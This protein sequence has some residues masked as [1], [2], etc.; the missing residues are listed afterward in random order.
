MLIT[1]GV[2]LA[3]NSLWWYEAGF[4][5]YHISQVTGISDTELIKGARGLIS[6]FNSSEEFINVTVEKDGEPFTLFN[7]REVTHLKDV[8]DLFWLDYKVALGTLIYVLAYGGVSLFYQRR[9]YWHQ[10][11]WATAIGSGLTLA[12]M[13]ALWIGSLINFE[14]LFIQFHLISFRNDFWELNPATDYLVMMF[15]EGFWNDT[16]FYIAIV[17]AVTAVVLG[18][19]AVG[20]LLLNKKDEA[21]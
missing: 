17:A 14:G 12:L 11:A 13:A 21:S 9:K 18:G 6:Y 19:L 8:K 16:V 10:L 7:Q 15:P 20:H 3:A 1:A 4:T 2:A 5:K